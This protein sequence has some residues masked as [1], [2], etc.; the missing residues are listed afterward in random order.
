[1]DYPFVAIEQQVVP[2]AVE[3]TFQHIVDT[4]ASETN[5]VISTWRAFSDQDIVFRPHP[6][7][8]TVGEIMKHELLSGRRFFGEF[9]Q[10][11]EPAG[12]AVLPDDFTIASCCHRMSVLA[13]RRLDFLASRT[14]EWWLGNSQFFD[15]ERQR[16]WIFWR[17]VLHT[18]HHRSQLTV[19]LRLLGKEVPPIYGPTADFS[20]SGADPTHTVAASQRR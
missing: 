20:W 17:R 12:A 2:Q 19:Y 7:S 9:L 4:Y 1:M 3:G 15:V 8:S 18:A 13:R 6:N 5:K 14:E 11:P 16:I 10:G